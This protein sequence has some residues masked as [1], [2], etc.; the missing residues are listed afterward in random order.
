MKHDHDAEVDPEAVGVVVVE[1]AVEPADEEVIEYGEDPGR[2]N[3]VVCADVRQDGDLGHEGHLGRDEAAE[4]RS[5]RPAGDP[6][7]KRLKYELRAA[8]C[9]LLPPGKLVVHGQRDAFLKSTVVDGGKSQV[10]SLG[11]KP[12]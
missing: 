9:I 8:I 3:G 1:V 2:T 7:P 10:I 12:Q 4:Q 11:L 5:E 6:V